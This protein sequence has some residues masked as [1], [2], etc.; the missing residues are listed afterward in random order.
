MELQPLKS[1]HLEKFKNVTWE[2]L[3]IR[4]DRIL[5]EIL[6][7]EEMKTK[8]GLHIA[9][10]LSDLKSKAEMHRA[11]L[12]IVLHKGNGYVDE[13]GETVDIDVE[14]GAVVMVAQAS[15][16]IYS[17]MPGI[18][19]YTEETLGMIRENA[20]IAYWP[21]FEAYD[22]YRKALIS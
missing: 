16:D 12:C 7:K 22:T 15:L 9:S 18:S 5:V 11:R 4:G 6:P 19:Q 13:E 3:P 8:S 1:L 10:S 21:T 17:D 14:R 2:L 20:I